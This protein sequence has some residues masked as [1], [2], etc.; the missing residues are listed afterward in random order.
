MPA[1][2]K[3][4]DRLENQEVDKENGYQA[5]NLLRNYVHISTRIGA[6]GIGGKGKGQRAKVEL[7]GCVTPAHAAALARL[8]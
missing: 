5:S 4:P 1:G 6:A 2:G 7:G 3:A 8:V